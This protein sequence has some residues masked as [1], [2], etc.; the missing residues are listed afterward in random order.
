MPSLKPAEKA[1]L[2]WIIGPYARTLT[3]ETGINKGW[4]SKIRYRWL[5]KR[6]DDEE[7]N[8]TNNF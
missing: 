8:N 6:H 5:L 2:A 3:D 1:I 4:A 7:T